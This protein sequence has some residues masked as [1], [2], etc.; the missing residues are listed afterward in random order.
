MASQHRNVE[1]LVLNRINA[2]NVQIKY[3][4]PLLREFIPKFDAQTI[5]IEVAICDL[6]DKMEK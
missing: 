1:R 2:L 4:G 6:Y 3:P 5:E